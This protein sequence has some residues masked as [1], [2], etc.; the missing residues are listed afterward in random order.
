MRDLLKVSKDSMIA[1][2]GSCLFYARRQTRHSRCSAWVKIFSRGC[3]AGKNMRS[4]KK[5]L[6]RSYYT[7]YACLHELPNS[8]FPLN[9]MQQIFSRGCDAGKKFEK[10]PALKKLRRSLHDI[11]THVTPLWP[12]LGFR[13]TLLPSL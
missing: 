9:C 1:I 11:I 12:P 5:K 4:D 7:G 13:S 10:S 8:P 6:R 2:Y 3:D